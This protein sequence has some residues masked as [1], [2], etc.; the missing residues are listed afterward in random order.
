MKKSVLT[1]GIAGFT[2]GGASTAGEFR[3]YETDNVDNSYSEIYI[4]SNSSGNYT[5]EV[6]A[7]RVYWGEITKQ[8][9]YVTFDGWLRQT[10][11]TTI[12]SPSKFIAF[13]DLVD[14]DPSD[15]LPDDTED[16]LTGAPIVFEGYAKTQLGTTVRVGVTSN[17]IIGG[18]GLYVLDPMPQNS[19]SISRYA[20]KITW[21]VKE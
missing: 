18:N 8:G 12:G 3:D 4:E 21:N 7:D 19:S 20:V 13:N 5:S 9:K 11:G 2:D 10:L 15:I 1:N 6:N 17:T 14:G 16:P